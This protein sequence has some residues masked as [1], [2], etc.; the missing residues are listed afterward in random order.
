[1]AHIINLTAHPVKD[2]MTGIEYP[3]SGTVA[4]VAT[5]TKH[6]SFGDGTTI[7]RTLYGEVVGLCTDRKEGVYYIVSSVVL[8]AV[9]IDRPDCMAPSGTVRGADNCV[10]GCQGFRRV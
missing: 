1:M 5:T 9:G 2:L 4:R 7:Y 3:I 10:V 6:K 8:N